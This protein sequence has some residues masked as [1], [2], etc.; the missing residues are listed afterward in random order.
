VQAS[1]RRDLIVQ[2][3]LGAALSFRTNTFLGERK[4]A[5][6]ERTNTEANIGRS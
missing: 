4:R 5:R 1:L 6:G 3:V 2:K